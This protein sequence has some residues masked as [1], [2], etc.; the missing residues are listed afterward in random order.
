MKKK[1]VSILSIF[2]CFTCVCFANDIVSEKYYAPF[3]LER[4]SERGE[5]P[6][7][8][9]IDKH[10]IL[11]AKPS[12]PFIDS[13]GNLM[14]SALLVK[15]LLGGSYQYNKAEKM[16]Q[17]ELYGT[18]Y[19]F[20]EGSS[21]VMVNGKSIVAKASAIK[22]DDSVLIPIRVLLDHSKIKHHYDPNYNQ[23]HITD[24]RATVSERFK[25][26]EAEVFASKSSDNH[27]ITLTKYRLAGNGVSSFVGVNGSNRTIPEGAGEI[28][29]QAI[30]LDEEGQDSG[31]FESDNYSRGT[32]DKL[33]QLKAKEA[34]QRTMGFGKFNEEV[35]YITA[36]GRVM[37]TFE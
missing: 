36:I 25:H 12:V 33:P 9:K 26:T 5:I 29:I 32:L 15:H 34:V 27:A 17:L 13:K 10:Y 7:R 30:L 2:I 8:L 22:H 20:M 18:K 3:L 24:T 16:V 31:F 23:L 6:I 28:R 1:I 35:A 14:I 19:T 4:V 11:Y 37:P 21:M